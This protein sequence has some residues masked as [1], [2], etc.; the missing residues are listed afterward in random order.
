MFVPNGTVSSYKSTEGWSKFNKIVEDETVENDLVSNIYIDA[1]SITLQIGETKQLTA[2]VSPDNATDKSVTWTS[3]NNSVATVSSNGLVTAKS[4]GT[5]T[6]TCK[7]NDGSGKSA[8]CTITVKKKVESR[9]VQTSATGYAT[10]YSSE[11]AYTLP[12]GLSAQVVTGCTNSKISYKTIADGSVSGVIPK[13]T[14]VMLVSDSKRAGTYTL[15]PSESTTSYAGTNYLHGS[16]NTTTT[17]ASG[18]NYYYKLTYGASGSLYSNIFGWYWGAQDGGAFQM[19][20]HKAWLA[21]PKTATRSSAFSIDGEAT[22][23]DGVE[24][25]ADSEDVYYD[26]SGRRIGKPT[27]SGVYILNGKKVFIRIK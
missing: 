11:S 24:C 3:S 13:A 20:G 12:N 2:T 25:D 14:A 15:T 27:V 1:S 21:V 26:L 5:A 23:I 22:D 16:D 19:E 10:F 17:S 6:I 9:K 4:A 7:S 8:T 18:S